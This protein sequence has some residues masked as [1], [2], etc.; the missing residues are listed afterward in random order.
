MSFLKRAEL[1][2]HINENHDSTVTPKYGIIERLK[3]G[4]SENSYLKKSTLF[5]GYKTKELLQSPSPRAARPPEIV[6]KLL[7]ATPARNPTDRKSKPRTIMTPADKT[8][9]KCWATC[10]IA[11]SCYS[12]PSLR[13]TRSRPTR[14]TAVAR[15]SGKGITSRIA[16]ITADHRSTPSRT[17]GK[18]TEFDNTGRSMDCDAP[19]SSYNGYTGSPI[20]YYCSSDE[21]NDDSTAEV[22]HRTDIKRSN[23]PQ[24]PLEYFDVFSVDTLEESETVSIGEAYTGKG[25]GKGNAGKSSRITRRT[26]ARNARIIPMPSVVIEKYIPPYDILFEKIIHK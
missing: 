16:Q 14:L 18:S 6:S 23:T 1:E 11:S 3:A 17:A 20:Q 10:S 4:K 26:Q 9:E 8:S 13:T 12:K 7:D 22:T 19:L 15:T 24:E 25:I 2:R 5:S 21:D